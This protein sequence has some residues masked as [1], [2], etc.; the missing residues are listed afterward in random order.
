MDE[1]TV[2]IDQ[3]SRNHILES[4]KEMKQQ[5]MTILYSTHYMEEVDQIVDRLLI[6]DLGQKIVEGPIEEIKQKHAWLLSELIE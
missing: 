3:Q 4:I 5:G 2:G 1:L 6:L